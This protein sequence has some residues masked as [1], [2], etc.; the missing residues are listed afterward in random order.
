VVT[1]AELRQARPQTYRR[2]AVAWTALVG[3]LEEQCGVVAGGG[4]GLGHGWS[5]AAAG[6][7]AGRLSVLGGDLGDGA[8][9]AGRIPRILDEHAGQVEAAQATVERVLAAIAA[10][11]IRVSVA[12]TA[13]LSPA[14]YAVPALVPLWWRLAGQ[15]QA[16]LDAAVQ[17]ATAA[18]TAAAGRLRALLPPMDPA[19]MD[20]AWPAPTDRAAVPPDQVPARGT[21]P[22]TVNQWWRGLSQEQRD[23]LLANHPEPVG[24]LDGVPAQDRDRANR[25]VLA[26][27]VIRLELRRGELVARTDRADAGDGELRDLDDKLRGIRAI[28]RRLRDAGA[29]KQRPYLMGLDTDGRGHAIVS[30]GNPDIADNVVTFVPGTTTRL[31]AMGVDVGWADIMVDSARAADPSEGT[32]AIAWVGYDA[33]QDVI[34]TDIGHLGEDATSDRYALQAR[35]DLDRFQDGLRATHD[36][37]RSHNTVVGHSYGTT[38]VGY[39][40][41]DRGLDADEVIFV[42]S[43]GVGVDHAGDLGIPPEHVWSST[44]RNDPIQYGYDLADVARAGLGL[45]PRIDLVHGANPSSPQFGGQVFAS[46]P[47]DPVVRWE[48]ERHGPFDGIPV[49]VP[50]FSVNAHSQYWDPGSASLENMGQIIV[51]NRPTRG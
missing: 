40:A 21:D 29:G 28:D 39:T 15:V 24:N 36:G 34:N 7:A 11:P 38:V 37:P 19:P 20:P 48:W 18:D 3:A 30:M 22:R 32:A 1:F 14:A 8:A 23:W 35:D 31:G 42:G 10:T 47:G 45:D 2:A 17:R 4:A 50:R 51:G 33:P 16:V 26:A 43:P 9:T 49:P 5:G 25:T 46:D 27:T 44:A 13:G 6:A 12:G 41:R